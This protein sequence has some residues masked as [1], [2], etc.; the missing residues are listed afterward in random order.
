MGLREWF[1]RPP[2]SISSDKEF[3]LSSP[4]ISTASDPSEGCYAVYTDG[5]KLE[6]KVV[7]AAY[8]PERP[9]CS[10]AIRLQ[11]GSIVFSAELKGIA[12]ALTEKKTTIK[13]HKNVV[14]YIDS[15]SALQPIQ[16]K[17]LGEKIF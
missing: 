4:F 16:S 6:E 8:F 3:T 7:A 11:E 10:K 15:L 17:K 5:S 14:T 12:L 13:C 1:R 9:G 2:M